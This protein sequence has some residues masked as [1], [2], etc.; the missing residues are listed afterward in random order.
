M[1]VGKGASTVH[2]L[3]G[4]DSLEEGMATPLQCSCLEN[5]MEGGAWWATVHSVA[6]SW[7]QLKLVSTHAHAY[8]SLYNAAFLQIFLGPGGVSDKFS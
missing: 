6:K 2:S 5:P 7:T 8:S 3:G 1:E 4:E